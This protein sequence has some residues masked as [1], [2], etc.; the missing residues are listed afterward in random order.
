M[1]VIFNSKTRGF[2]VEERLV[3]QIIEDAG[4]KGNMSICIYAHI[5]QLE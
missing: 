2:E 3:Y 5:L 4:N 1:Y